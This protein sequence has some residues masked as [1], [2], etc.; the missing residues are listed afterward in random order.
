[1]EIKECKSSNIIIQEIK[2][3]MGEIKDKI[4][5]NYSKELN[6]YGYSYTQ[7]LAETDIRKTKL[8][9][10]IIEE[11]KEY[12]DIFAVNFHDRILQ[13]TISDASE[14]VYPLIKDEF[15]QFAELN[16][17]SIKSICFIKDF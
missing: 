8:F 3:K 2:Q 13:I 16:K 7:F 12:K 1:M 10:W 15:T 5:S 17:N 4:K 6:I 9:G 11:T 14:F